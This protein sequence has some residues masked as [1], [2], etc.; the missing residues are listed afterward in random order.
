MSSRRTLKLTLAYD[1]AAYAGWQRQPR[2][3]SVQ[4]LL[5]LALS[6]LD[7]APVTV[8]GAGRTDAGV[9]ALGQVARASV[10]TARDPATIRRALNAILP[11]D[12]RVLAV[13]EAPPSFH[14][15]FD[16]RSKTYQ[17]WIWDDP[18]VPPPVRSWC[19]RVPRRLDAAAMDRA[20]GQ[21]VGEHDFAA[22]Q[23]SGSDVRTTR[24]TMIEARV[25][26]IDAAGDPDDPGQMV[27]RRLTGGDGRFLVL[28][29]EANGFLRHM[30]RAIAGTLVEVGDG[31]RPAEEMAVL[32]D[33]ASRGRAGP[34]APPDGLVMLRV[35]Y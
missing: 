13:E 21:L 35:S 33:G 14:P 5:E 9:H 29:V 11:P 15:R 12:V 18:V 2:G 23:S 17:Y 4:G 6:R 8:V 32:L 19:W 25:L 24:R 1:G 7:G 26:T 22:F 20:A 27:L 34:T 3:T 30:V 31:R 10:S 16:A 28:H